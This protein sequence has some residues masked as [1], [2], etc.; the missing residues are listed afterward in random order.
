MEMNRKFL[1][2]VVKTI[3]YASDEKAS[4]PQDLFLSQSLHIPL[5]GHSAD[6]FLG[7]RPFGKSI[8]ATECGGNIISTLG[9]GHFNT[10][11]HFLGALS[12]R[13]WKYGRSLS[14]A[15]KCRSR[16]GSS[17]CISIQSAGGPGSC[18]RVSQPTITLTNSQKGNSALHPSHRQGFRGGLEAT[19][20]GDKLQ[21]PN[22]A[23]SHSTS[24]GCDERSS[25][26]SWVFHY[27]C[28]PTKRSE[29]ERWRGLS[30]LVLI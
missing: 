23:G 4:N 21:R 2:E 17:A 3:V 9:G 30:E 16:S 12:S 27:Q 1:Y 11:R 15:E 29:L 20:A 28:R 8:I 24:V 7:N 13:F 25:I 5:I 6:I 26:E 14:R 22:A 18:I 19:H 10:L